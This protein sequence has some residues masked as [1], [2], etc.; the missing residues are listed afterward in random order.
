MTKVRPFVFPILEQLVKRR[1][2]RDEF[3]AL[4]PSASEHVSE[5]GFTDLKAAFNALKESG[6]D[7]MP[8]VE[9]TYRELEDLSGIVAHFAASAAF[10]EDE[11]KKHA[12][13]MQQEALERLSESTKSEME[14]KGP[15]IWRRLHRMALDWDGDRERLRVILSVITN[16]VPCGS[17]KKHWVEMITAKPPVCKTAEEFFALTVDWHNE[18][19]A[20]LEKPVISLEEALALHKPKS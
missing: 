1:R 15:E 14:M 13:A 3:L 8:W 4:F 5:N 10:W 11:I 12:P 6:A 19:N 9:R 17:C 16:S 18:V 7:W 20:R 2:F